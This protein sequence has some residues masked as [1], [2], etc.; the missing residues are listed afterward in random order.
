MEKLGQK[1]SPLKKSTLSK[2]RENKTKIILT[3][4]IKAWCDWKFQINWNKLE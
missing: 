3:E 1:L 2:K 4:A